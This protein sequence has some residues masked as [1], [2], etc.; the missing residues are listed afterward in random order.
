VNPVFGVGE[1]T[2]EFVIK[3]V[4]TA[5][6]GASHATKYMYDSTGAIVHIDHA[7]VSALGPSGRFYGKFDP[8][9]CP[10]NDDFTVK[11]EA[12]NYHVVAE[13]DET[14]NNMTVDITCPAGPEPGGPD[15][16]IKITQ[17]VQIRARPVPDQKLC[18]Y[19]V[20]WTATNIGNKGSVA[21]RVALFVD[22]NKVDDQ[23]CAALGVG[24]S[25]N[26]IFGWFDCPPCVTPV[27]VEVIVDYF[28]KVDESNENNNNDS[29]SVG[30]RVGVI[31]VTKE[32]WEALPLPGQWVDEID[33]AVFDQDVQFRCT[34][35]NTGCCCDLT[36]ITVT[37][38]LS[39]SLEYIDAVP[40]P[41][42]EVIILPDGTATL[43]W[44]VAAPQIPLKPDDELVY[45][46]NARVRGCGEDTNTQ[47]A[48]A[49]TCTGKTVS[50]SDKATVKVAPGPA[51]GADKKVKDAAG[52]WVD[53]PIS[54]GIGVDIEYQN[55]VHNSGCCDL[56]KGEVW[57]TLPVGLV[58]QPGSGVPTP[59]VLAGP[60]GTTVLKWTI[61]EPYTHCTTLTYTYK[62][63]IAAAGNYVNTLRARGYCETKP[64]AWVD[65]FNT[66]T[67]NNP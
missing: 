24:A 39:G 56:T 16:E 47:S 37:D 2:V 42:D 67:V 63:Q 29:T 41:D 15:L 57:D 59:I 18:E 9:P 20:N 48:V 50:H 17:P 6:A 34:V 54:V 14:N 21:N 4:G 27:N 11:V 61:S 33:N 52:N 60:A 1:V 25:D 36:G 12:D 49:T 10:P 23:P 66:V 62:A 53:G 30:C 55:T 22:G 32:V 40:V 44:N 26:D 7:S 8:E 31:T 45:I 19:R 13:S 28:K 64:V 58:Y 5:K 43:K 51:I 38:V 3:N 46:I 65:N 35:K